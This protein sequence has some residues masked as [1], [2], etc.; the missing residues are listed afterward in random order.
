[1]RA[2][3]IQNFG[4]SLSIPES[5][6]IRRLSNKFNIGCE[7]VILP[8]L[9]QKTSWLNALK[10]SSLARKLDKKMLRSGIPKSGHL[11]IL[12]RMTINHKEM[13]MTT[14]VRTILP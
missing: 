3:R 6:Q 7:H 4:I 8:T 11:E 13:A 5:R 10:F 14:Q 9:T 1:M 2:V 12:Q